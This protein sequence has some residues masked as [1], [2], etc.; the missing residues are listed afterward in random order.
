M[1]II[2]TAPCSLN[3]Q[4]PLKTGTKCNTW[5][6]WIL[7]PASTPLSTGGGP[8]GTA[9]SAPQPAITPRIGY[10]RGLRLSYAPFNSEAF[11]GELQHERIQIR[12][13][14]PD[15]RRSLCDRRERDGQ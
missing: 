11:D 15:R 1:T 5:F 2:G 14:D 10:G 6:L 3:C 9:G 12:A 8:R 13:Q 4:T 7:G